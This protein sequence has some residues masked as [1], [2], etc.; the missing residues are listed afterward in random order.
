QDFPFEDLVERVAIDRDASRNPLFDVMLILQNIDIEELEIPGMRLLP[1]EH[2]LVTSKFD[3]TLMGFEKEE[4]LLLTFEYST[5]LFKKTTIERFVA[6]LKKVVSSVITNPDV[7]IWELEIL[8]EEE[9]RQVLYDFNNTTT[10]YPKDKVIYEFFA[11]Q[12]KKTPDTIAV[13]GPLLS[14]QHTEPSYKRTTE[15]AFKG[16]FSYRKLN[17]ISDQLAYVLKEKHVGP[18][19]IVG[20]IMERSIEMFVCIMGILKAGGAYLPIDAEYPE[21]RVRFMF[22]DSNVRIFLSGESEWSKVR[23]WIEQSE[24]T[25]KTEGIKGI[26]VIEI[27]DVHMPPRVNYHP[28]QEGSDAVTASVNSLVYVLYTSGST[29]NPKGVPIQQGSVLNILWALFKKYPLL[30]KDTYL[31]KTTYTFDVSVSELF[32]WYLGGGRLAILE[33]GGEKDPFTILDWIERVGVTHINFVPS[34]F[35]LF[36][37]ILDSRKVS[38]LS[39]LKYIF[40]AGEAL[41]PHL[42]TR[43]NAFNTGITVENIYGPTENTIYASKYSL[44]QWSRTGSIPIGKPLPNVTLYILDQFAQVQPIGIPGELSIGGVGVARGY[45]NKPELTADKFI[46]AHS[47]WLIANRMEK[48]ASSPGELPMSYQL[49]AMSYL[50]KTGDLARWLEDGNIEFLGRIDHQVKIRGFR[51]EPGEIENQLL[52]HDKIRKAVVLTREVEKGDR[53]LCAYI[54]PTLAPSSEAFDVTGLRNDLLKFLPDYMIPS[55]FVQVDDIP[56]TPTGKIDRSALPAVEIGPGEKYIAP[57]DALESGLVD[58][59]QEVLPLSVPI[60]IEDHFFQL[61]GHSLKAVILLSKIHQAFHVKLTLAEIFKKPT[62]RGLSEHIKHAVKEKYAPIEVTEQKEYYLLSSA[63]QR[64]YLLQ[65]MDKNGTVYNMPLAWAWEGSLNRDRLEHTFRK[66]I[67]R[68]ESLRTSFEL[69]KEE[70]VQKIHG[71]IEF[72]I[73]YYNV[74][75]PIEVET[76]IHHFIEPF[77]LSQPPLL[78]MGLIKVEEKAGILMVDMHHIITDGVSTGIFI[79]D[80]MALYGGEKLPLI[81]IQYK[82]CSEWLGSQ[83]KR[84]TLTQQKSYWINE[85]KEEIPVVNL[86]LDYPR[87]AV[88]SYE[89]SRMEFE[90][91]REETGQLETLALEEELTLYTVLLSLFNILLSKISGQEDIV[92]GSPTAGRKHTDLQQ[93]IGV[94]INTLALRN[95]PSGEKT[96]QEFLREVR[97]KTL[98]AQENQDYPFEELVEMVEVNR[99]TGRNPLFDIML[100]WQNMDQQELKIP[101]LKL[102]EYPLENKK[103]KFDMTLTGVEGDHKLHF[104]ITYNTA[105]FHKKTIRRFIG[106]FK[107]IV[108]DILEDPGKIISEIDILPQEEKK[109]LLIDFNDTVIGYPKEKTIHQLFETQVEKTPD[110]IAIIG[111]WHHRLAVEKEVCK[112]EGVGTPSIPSTPGKQTIQVTYR[113]LNEKTNQLARLLKGR[114]GAAPDLIIG[115]M[116]GPSV[117]MIIGI[118]TIL[119]VGGAYLPMDHNHPEDRIIYMINDSEVKLILTQTPYLHKIPC[120][121]E[122]I[123]IENV[124]IYKG[125]NTNLEYISGPADLVYTIYTSGSTGKPK[126]VLLE[127]KNLV[128]YVSWFTRKAD[129]RERDRTVLTSSF[130]FDLGYT[131]LYSSIL[132]GCQLHIP[133]EEIYLSPKNLMDYIV[134]HEISYMKLTPSLFGTIIKSGEFTAENSRNLRIVA[135]GGEE[136]KLKDVEK[137]HAVGEHIRIMNHYGPTEA[138]IGCVAQFIDFS[139]F[140]DYRTRPTIGHPIHNMKVVILDKGLKMVATGVPGE[141]CV[142]GEGVVRGYL[143]RPELTAEK[144]D[145]DFWDYHDYHDEKKLNL[146]IK[147]YKQKINKKLFRGVQGG[148]FLEKSPPMLHGARRQKIYKTGDLTRWLPGGI[149]QFL[150]RIDSQVKI[151]GYR[152][153]LGEI[154]KR[155]LTHEGI[156]EAVVIIREH[157]SADKYLCA[158]IVLKNPGSINVPALKEHLAIELPDYMIPTF[159]VELERIPLTPNG[160]VNRKLLPEP[161]LGGLAAYYAAPRN[162]LEQKLAE[163]W[164]EILEVDRIGIDDQFFQLGGHSLK[165]IILIS[166]MNK[167]F[168]VTVPLAEIFRTPTIRGLSAYITSKQQG[169]FTPIEPEEEKDYHALSSAQKRLYFLHQLD[170]GS[171]SYNMPYVLRLEGE[172]NRGKLAEIFLRLIARHESLRTSFGMLDGEPVQRIHNDVEFELEYDQSLVNGHWSL[173]NCQGRGEVASPIK[174]EKITGDFIRPFDLSHAPLLRVRLIKLLHTPTDLG[175]HPCEEGKENKYLLMVD[176]HHIISDGISRRLLVREFMALAAEKDLAPLR[177][178]YKDFSAWQNRDAQREAQIKQKAY[179]KKQLAGE[180]PVLDLPSDYV[181]PTMQRFEG[182]TVSFEIVQEE[183]KALQSLALAEGMTLY[184]I[185]LAI[186]YILLSK[187]SNQEDIL[188]GTPTIGRRHADLEQIIGMFVNTLVLRNYLP[189]DKTYGAFLKEIKERTLQAFENQDY[190]YEELVEEVVISRDASRNPLFDTMFVLQNMEIPRI[191]IPGLKLTPDEHRIETSKFDLT[192][193]ATEAEAGLQ[194]IFEYSTCLFKKSTIE[195]FTNYFK[196]VVSVVISNPNIKICEVE[197]V[198]EEEKSEILYNF[199]DTA[200]KYPKDKTIDRLFEEQTFKVP[201]RIAVISTGGRKGSLHPENGQQHLSY[202]DLNRK[203]NQLAYMLMEKGG[204]PD[205]MVGIIAERSPEMIVGIVAIL[206]AGGV[207]LPIQP[208]YPCERKTF[209]LDDS[210]AHILLIS[211][212]V[213]QGSGFKFKGEIFL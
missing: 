141:L 56:L 213:T 136:M 200:V 76:I 142:S 208:D 108:L 178:Q 105:L 154:E 133:E 158:Y 135:L 57:R 96:V 55:Y 160:K 43:F 6:Y 19:T 98:K 26:K 65:Q 72:A 99:D 159:F 77:D 80:F 18:D 168:H 49:S 70:P 194:L 97:A 132:S 16:A 93:V 183:V 67:Q 199:N 45:L 188:V 109:Q 129:L 166:R 113:E 128:N 156:N 81:K 41:A 47:S 162:P 177:L 102:K 13:I 206:K 211:S 78:R 120:Q 64:L 186:Y 88:Q 204:Q 147:N 42:V 187:L 190:P 212:A 66:L 171:T 1:Y 114:G 205:F 143:N 36:L 192:L 29:G 138:T 189:G 37:E 174:V 54:V 126:G 182:S 100:V 51:I 12:A 38:Q 82:D 201:D 173:V 84:K 163:V 137:V 134:K 197:I 207:Y 83:K 94:F 61:G 121:I 44:S 10:E 191:E 28:F 62:I 202:R 210:N 127:H 106:Y 157:P 124:E 179:W 85:F 112:G 150:G 180:I 53:Y 68:H 90:L 104:T 196:K 17:K 95:Y 9:K 20:V 161:E 33:P 198:G 48:K 27:G 185:L 101:G 195:R 122:S 117:A 184:M 31:F 148:G 193:T 165:A 140:S 3:L 103:S 15:A 59:W 123:N 115:I 116:T 203:A 40:L 14:A 2:Q 92:I 69:V 30:K 153:E 125:K 87:P 63:Q 35:G 172:V 110:K 118:M 152:I 170:E 107:H 151:R 130:A 164:Q 145:H 119:K 209:M 71:E 73:E 131:S 167:A 91:G 34:M 75:S 22:A 146:S 46:L 155:L 176:M 139:R 86:P 149:I 21:D 5:R 79:R 111:S 32:G 144:F 8:M 23:G 52:K 4:R 25:G 7:K 175:G 89:G 169:L 181:R 60:G 39:N 24:K 74:T 50:Y 11:E 58:I